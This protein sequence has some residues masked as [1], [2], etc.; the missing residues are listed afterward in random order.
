MNEILD[1]KYLQ[2]KSHWYTF[3]YAKVPSDTTGWWYP[4]GLFG[5]PGTQTY[6]GPPT[7]YS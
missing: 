7:V 3:F 1:G 2:L 4:R 5:I 6:L